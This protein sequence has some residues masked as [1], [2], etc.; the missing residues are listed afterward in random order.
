MNQLNWITDIENYEQH[1]SN[2]LKEYDD[3]KLLYDILQQKSGSEAFLSIAST[4]LKTNVKIIE[5]PFN[6]M[7]KVFVYQNRDL[8]VAKLAREMGVDERTIYSWLAEFGCKKNGGV[9]D[10]KTIDMFEG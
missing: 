5:K 6:E 10:S 7:K 9:K 8:P 3:L 1:L 4:F 2:L